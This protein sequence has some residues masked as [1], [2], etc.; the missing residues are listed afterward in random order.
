MGHE[1][2]FI[3]EAKAKMLIAIMDMDSIPVRKVMLP[4][5]E[6]MFISARQHLR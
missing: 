2:G 3:P 4:L 6:M 1:E 5:N